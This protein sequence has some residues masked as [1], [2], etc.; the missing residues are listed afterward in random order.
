VIANGGVL[1]PAGKMYFGFW[2]TWR[3]ASISVRMKNSA[4]T[5]YGPWAVDMSQ[6]DNSNPDINPVYSLPIVG[7]SNEI[8]EVEITMTTR[9]DVITSPVFINWFVNNPQYLRGA[10]FFDKNLSN[11]RLFGTVD[12]ADNSANIKASISPT[13]VYF[14]TNVGV[15]TSTISSSAKLEVQST[16]SGLLLPRMT[17]TQRDAIASPADGLL[18]YNTS[19][20]KF[21]GRAGGAWVDLH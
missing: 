3:P 6:G 11:E 10:R 13:N 1:Y 18:I 16:T 9:S 12:W 21:Q 19:T 5:W 15:G 7:F 2:D 17:T 4:G 14:N 20:S 8:T